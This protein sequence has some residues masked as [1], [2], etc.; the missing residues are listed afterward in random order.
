M[1]R[2]LALL[3]LLVAAS[4]HGQNLTANSVRLYPASPGACPS[5]RVCIVGTSATTPNRVA[6]QDSGGGLITMGEAWYLRSSSGAPSSPMNGWIWYDSAAGIGYY[7]AAGVNIPFGSTAANVLAALAAASSPVD[8][9]GQKIIDVG[10][11][12]LS[13][14]AATKGYVDAIEKPFL[15]VCTLTSAA[16]ATPVV[17]LLDVD[18]PAGKKAYVAGVRL[19]VNGG[20]PWGT[21]T[22]CV[23]EDTSAIDLLTIPV[24][25]LS[26]N[27]L[28][29]DSDTTLTT[30]EA[31]LALG[32]GTTTAKGLRVVCNANGT[33]DDQVWT[34]WGTI[35]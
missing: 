3:L 32:S 33:G 5:G 9:N 16:A 22:S 1:T 23:L 31:A 34:I 4:A 30:T 18:V 13:T 24:A 27:A 17:C 10:A 14:D 28:L 29:F 7:R 15:R 6:F 25:S 8:V 19:K 35:R 2:L 20:T 26:G 11:P 21:V 12:T